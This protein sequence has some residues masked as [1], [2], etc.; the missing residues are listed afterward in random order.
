MLLAFDALFAD[1]AYQEWREIRNV[2]THRTA[3]GRRMYV[4]IGDDDAPATEWKLN[5]IPLDSTMAKGRRAELAR[6]LGDLLS[7]VEAFISKKV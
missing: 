6:M 1:P 5:S 4:G 3:P 2:L 7:A